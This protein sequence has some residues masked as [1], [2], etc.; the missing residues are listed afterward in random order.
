MLAAAALVG[1]SS[2]ESDPTPSITPTGE[3]ASIFTNGITVS[4]AAADISLSF[5]S[6]TDWRVSVEEMAYKGLVSWAV[7]TPASGKGGDVNLTVSILANTEMAP[8]QAVL[9]ILSG[10]IVKS[11]PI[12]Q[13]GREKILITGVTLSRPSVEFYPGETLTLTA[14]V[15]PSTTDEDKTVT[16]KSSDPSIVTVADGLLTAIAEGTAVITASAGSSASAT[17]NVTVL[18]RGSGGEDLGGSTDVDPWNN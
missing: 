1:C 7:A 17:C 8:R 13:G 10:D 15:T 9:Q 2:A 16:W 12:L 4:S 5:H 11:I 14:T 18:H 3:S 6:A